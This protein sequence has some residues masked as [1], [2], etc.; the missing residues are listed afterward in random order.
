MFCSKRFHTMHIVCID[1]LC[2]VCIGLLFAEFSTMNTGLGRPMCLLSTLEG[3]AT[4]NYQ[5]T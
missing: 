3:L 4:T 1:L 2:V 5:L